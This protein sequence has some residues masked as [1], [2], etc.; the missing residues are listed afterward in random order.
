MTDTIIGEAGEENGHARHI[1][2]CDG[3]N[4]TFSGTNGWHI[5]NER[6]LICGKNTNQIDRY[7]VS[8][9]MTPQTIVGY[10]PGCGLSEGQITAAHIIYENTQNQN[11]GQMKIAV[12]AIDYPESGILSE[13]KTILTN[14]LLPVGVSFAGN[15]Q[16]EPG[17]EI[18]QEESE[19]VQEKTVPDESVESGVGVSEADVQASQTEMAGTAGTE[20]PIVQEVE[21]DSSISSSLEKFQQ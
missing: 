18:R 9:N 21:N 10:R 16:E 13:S 12:P 11:I 5:H 8:C 1:Y 4:G 17:T 6:A 19:S 14:D 20:V 7:T 3:C 2:H 15:A